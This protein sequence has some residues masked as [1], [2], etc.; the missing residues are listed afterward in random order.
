MVRKTHPPPMKS[1]D[2]N[3]R[4]AQANIPNGFNEE[5]CRHRQAVFRSGSR[6]NRAKERE[7]KPKTKQ[8]SSKQN[9][10]SKQMKGRANGVLRKQNKSC[11]WRRTARKKQ[12]V[13]RV[14][15]QLRNKT[16]SQAHSASSS[17]L[18]SPNECCW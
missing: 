4:T 14:T 3:A 13:S 9:S 5:A 10:V 7:K 16:Y 6:Y 17:I 18:I 1:N 11:H 12:Q 8:K 2:H 15:S